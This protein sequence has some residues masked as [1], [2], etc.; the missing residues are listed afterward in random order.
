MEQE[1]DFESRN[2][3]D[4]AMEASK[5]KA[6]RLLE[7]PH[8]TQAAAE[9]CPEE[10]HFPATKAL[11]PLTRE[12]AQSSLRRLKHLESD[13]A[14]SIENAPGADLK[15]LK[16]SQE[17]GIDVARGVDVY[18]LVLLNPCLGVQA[19]MPWAGEVREIEHSLNSLQDLSLDQMGCP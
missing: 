3:P 17:C 12:P 2:E 4:E 19:R 18:R 15:G 7:D 6:R 10:E 16:A 9:L 14:C 13:V 5:E 11:A 1:L 8:V